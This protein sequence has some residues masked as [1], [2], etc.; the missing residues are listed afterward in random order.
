MQHSYD[1]RDGWGDASSSS[2]AAPAPA[3]GPSLAVRL[4]Q[5]ASEFEQSAKR[6][7][8]RL[9]Q[10]LL[11][12]GDERAA[13]ERSQRDLREQNAALTRRAA[14]LAADL[15]AQ[16]AA[17]EG[18]VRALEAA[19]MAAR[20]ELADRTSQLL[21]LHVGLGDAAE[22]ETRLLEAQQAQPLAAAAAAA[23]AAQQ[24]PPS[25]NVLGPS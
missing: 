7:R 16:G 21:E 13:L 25:A 3:A 6:E 22:R 15:E 14:K 2:S 20:F 4:M 10:R 18:R 23:A 5:V 12:A 8:T 1:D 17:H 19:L 11:A 24:P 9:E